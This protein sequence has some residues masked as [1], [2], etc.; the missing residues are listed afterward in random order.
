M[1]IATWLHLIIATWQYLIYFQRLFE[2]QSDNTLLLANK[3]SYHKNMYEHNSKLD[4]AIISTQV[5][6]MK[7]S[8]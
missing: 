7:V 2:C 6:S 4:C 5:D 3:A 8:I 1:I